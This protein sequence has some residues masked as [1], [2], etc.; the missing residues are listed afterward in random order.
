[1]REAESLL[2]E[3]KEPSVAYTSGLAVLTVGVSTVKISDEQLFSPDGL[4]PSSVDS[5][6]FLAKHGGA[7]GLDPVSVLFTSGAHVAVLKHLL[8]GLQRGLVATVVVT[9]ALTASDLVGV[10]LQVW[11]VPLVDSFCYAS[12]FFQQHACSPV[13]SRVF[14]CVLIGKEVSCA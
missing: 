10:V 4:A 8:D 1:M 7:D 5:Y 12:I 6:Y 14:Y 9:L 11:V 13:G 3:R 2:V